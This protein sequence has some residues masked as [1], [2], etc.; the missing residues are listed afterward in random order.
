MKRGSIFCL[1]ISLL[2]LLTSKLGAQGPLPDSFQLRLNGLGADLIRPVGAD[3]T[4]LSAKANRHLPTHFA[5]YSRHEKLEIR[6]TVFAE[7]E[8]GPLAGLP[9]VAVSHLLLDIGS[10]DE[11]A[12]LT[13]HSYVGESFNTFGA[14][15]AKLFTFRPKR[16]F[17]DTAFAQLVALYRE[18]LGMAYV[19]LLFDQAPETLDARQLAL[20]FLR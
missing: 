7:A 13:M 6:Y 5:L 8:L 20:R 3:F 14:D 9:H 19:F 1:L 11:D 17:C 10:N 4:V 12:F 15:W 2:L 18:G 16:S